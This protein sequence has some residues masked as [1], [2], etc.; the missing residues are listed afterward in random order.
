MVA[1]DQREYGSEFTNP[2]FVNQHRLAPGH[3]RI[4]KDGDQL[5]LS[6]LTIGVRML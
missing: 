6:G 4:L 5:R 3:R 1:I 2:T